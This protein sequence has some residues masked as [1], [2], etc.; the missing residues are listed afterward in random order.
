MQAFAVAFSRRYR[1]RNSRGQV[2]AFSAVRLP[3][4]ATDGNRFPYWRVTMAM[5]VRI[6]MH[7]LRSLE[8]NP[9]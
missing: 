3:I 8:E 9:L 2:P 5:I 7:P 6:A 1:E 4:D